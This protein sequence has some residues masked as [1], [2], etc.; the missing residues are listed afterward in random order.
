MIEKV[1]FFDSDGRATK[2]DSNRINETHPWQF[3]FLIAAT[4]TVYE[5][6]TAAMVLLGQKK[7]Y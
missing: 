4:T 2:A 3:Q 6:T 5:T 7:Q 1:I